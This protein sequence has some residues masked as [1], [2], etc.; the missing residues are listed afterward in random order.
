MTRTVNEYIVAY[1][2]SVVLIGCQ[3]IGFNTDGTG[4]FGQST[5]YIIGLETIYLQ[6]GY[7]VCFKQIFNDGNCLSDIFGC[8][9]AL[10][11]VGRESLA[12]EGRTMWI[13]CHADMGR[14]LFGE[15][16]VQCV[17]ESH[18]STRIQALRVDSRVFDK[19]IIAAI[20][21]RV[22]V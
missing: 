2:L 11:F 19:R 14:F 1:Q 4:F 3:H 13:E 17:Q 5:N 8:F 9:F 22:S 20:N 16:L 12:A 18:D 6:D 15:H 7:A 21:E 10:G